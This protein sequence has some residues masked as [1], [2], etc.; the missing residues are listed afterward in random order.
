MTSRR[1]WQ[2]LLKAPPARARRGPR[3]PPE[4]E[5][6]EDRTLLNAGA[7]DTSF[8]SGGKV[9][10][11]LAG[12][13]RS[14]LDTIAIQGDG[15]VVAV[16]T[17]NAFTTAQDFAVAR[18]N[19]DGSPDG[20]FG[21]GGLVTTD[22][23]GRNDQARGVV[24]QPDG[25]I[26]VGGGT[27]T[28]SFRDQFALT[29]YNPDGTLDTS[30]G[31]DHTGKVI[32][33]MGSDDFNLWD[34]ALQAD[35]K[36]VAVGDHG[37]FLLARYN[38]DGSLD[39]TFGTGGIVTTG[40]LLGSGGQALSAAIQ[41]DGKIVA[42][43]QTVGGRLAFARYNP[44]GSLDSGFGSGGIVVA[45]FDPFHGQ[46]IQG[47]ALQADGKI[48]GTGVYNSATNATSD[49][50]L[51]RLNP[52][53]TL[54]NSFGTGGLVTTDLGGS[55]ESGGSVVV[56]GDGHII[57]T[58]ARGIPG[59][60]DSL[61]IRYNADGSVDTNFGTNGTVLINYAPGGNDLFNVV[62]LQPDGKVVAAG[63][64]GGSRFDLVRLF[65]IPVPVA[66]AG[67]PYT[68]PE[69]GSVQLNGSASTPASPGDTLTY[70]W[71]FNGDG[72]FD[73]SG[74]Q[75]AF[76]AAA[77]D[78]PSTVTVTLRVTDN[79]GLTSTATA[80]VT[81][82]NVPPTASL[83]GA[84]ATSPEGTPLSITASATD[85]SLADTAAGFTLSWT[86]RRTRAGVTTTYAS[87]TGSAINFTPNDDGTYVVTVTARDKNGAFSAPATAS[88]TVT[89]VGPSVSV[90]GPGVAVPGQPLTFTFT[91]SD[92][93]SADQS[94]G[95]VYHIDWDGDGT[96]D[97]TV[98]G[99]ASVQVAHT[100]TATGSNTARVTATDKDQGT[101][102]E[103]TRAVSVT[104]AALEADPADASQTA[105][106]VG[107]TLGNDTVRLR[108]HQGSGVEVVLNGVSQGTFTPTGRLIIY[109]QAG[110]DDI[111][112]ASGVSLPAVVGGG[113]GNDTVQAG[114]G[115]SILLGGAG[116]DTL[117][118]GADRDVLI[119]GGGAD[120]LN[121]KGE[122]DILIGGGTAF[123]QDLV[124]LSAIAAEWASGNNYAT[125]ISHLQGANP[126]GLNGPYLLTS[127]TVSDD[128]ASDQLAGQAGTDW[129]FANL[130]GTGGLDVISDLGREELVT[131][132]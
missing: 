34:L 117:V 119:G 74:V 47:I 32:T 102:A 21:N 48:V 113:D 75:P 96:E 78:G 13:N 24:V 65:P 104:A 92:P 114:S 1:W 68:V 37:N 81:V 41:P 132:L 3:R 90:T 124:A 97:Q 28:A 88:I 44:D 71:D 64:D 17:Y 61:V 46:N 12:S 49:I 39:S 31:P 72:T 106:F 128:G 118:G 55:N 6:L 111:A 83:S 2:Q 107:G 89:N 80:T 23:S 76:S 129:F 5:R 127:A 7:L 56:Q 18:F 50:G 73:A 130:Q 105:L 86:V 63:D 121:G 54:D 108:A 85:P 4:L 99:G 29:R 43:G 53:G 14:L 27:L 98:S 19:T 122:S 52:D 87:G 22:L 8:G 109:G 95:F 60:T 57:V 33:P 93:S 40:G 100:Y 51:A 26:V 58:G 112:I 10:Y 115:P 20:T 82:T 70:E 67:G 126:G 35:G 59:G 25:K 91:A 16:G 9:V 66:N 120:Q 103:G 30:F 123:D 110:D 131:E 84:P 125:R 38:P 15:K 11:N 94:A 116:D 77:L 79:N 42:A 45:F 69:G 62:K 101:G 36:I